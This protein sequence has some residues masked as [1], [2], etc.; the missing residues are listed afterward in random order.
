MTVGREGGLHE[1][2]SF[3]PACLPERCLLTG[4]YFLLLLRLVR[5]VNVGFYLLF[6][7]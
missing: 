1:I 6:G 4:L 7:V 5:R 3:T 2:C